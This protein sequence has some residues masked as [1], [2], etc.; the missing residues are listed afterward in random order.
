MIFGICVMV[1]CVRAQAPLELL[2]PLLLS[3]LRAGY[4]GRQLVPRLWGFPLL[5]AVVLWGLLASDVEYGL[6]VANLRAAKIAVTSYALIQLSVGFAAGAPAAPVVGRGAFIGLRSWALVAPPLHALR[7]E[8]WTRLQSGREPVLQRCLQL[9]G[10][11]LTGFSTLLQV[12]ADMG[13]LWSARY[14]ERH[15]GHWIG[16]SQGVITVAFADGALVLSGCALLR[17]G[18]EA[19]SPLVLRQVALGLTGA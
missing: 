1:W 16:S 5:I 6:A 15:Y 9:A 8:A 13:R 14:L 11:P 2:L 7:R 18:P 3:W 17:W 12:S 10:A 19:L 4:L